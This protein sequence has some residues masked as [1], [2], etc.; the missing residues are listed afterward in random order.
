MHLPRHCDILAQ[1]RLPRGRAILP[2]PDFR[3]AFSGL[4]KGASAPMRRR[5]NA[6]AENSWLQHLREAPVKRDGVLL[7]QLGSRLALSRPYAYTVSGCGII[8]PL[9]EDG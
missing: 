4:R 1:P 6:I 3:T 8:R 9:V 5:F 7:R 2:G